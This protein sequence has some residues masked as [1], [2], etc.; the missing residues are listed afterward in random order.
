VNDKEIG[1]A[2]FDYLLDTANRLEAAF[3]D[4]LE[5]VALL[6]KNVEEWKRIY[7]SK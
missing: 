3:Q 1:I 4:S 7:E 5:E 2:N 6:K